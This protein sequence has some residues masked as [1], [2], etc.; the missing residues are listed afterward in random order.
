MSNSLLQ[1]LESHP[2][3]SDFVP[4]DRAAWPLSPRKSSSS[5][6]R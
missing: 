2:F 1:N 3:V 6:T 4:E 5:R